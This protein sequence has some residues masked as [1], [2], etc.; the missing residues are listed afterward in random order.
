MKRKWHPEELLEHWSIQPDEEH[1]LSRRQ[2]ANRLGFVLLLK[3]SNTKDA[4]LNRSM[5]FLVW[6]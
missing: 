3:F 5:R 4:S 2:G 1:L 6:P